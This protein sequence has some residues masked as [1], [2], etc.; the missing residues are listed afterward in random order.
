MRDVI[1]IEDIEEMRRLAGIDDVELR[2]DIR[3][4]RIG[5]IVKLTF[6]AGPGACES[7]F[8]RITS[9]RGSAFRGKLANN[10]VCRSLS[11]LHIG[12]AV[13][14]TANHI[15]SLKKQQPPP[16]A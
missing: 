1:E 14:F 4:L 15:H 3:S 5:D 8:V 12:S 7:L 9:I 11:K 10:P 13:A 6:S 2:R 16:E